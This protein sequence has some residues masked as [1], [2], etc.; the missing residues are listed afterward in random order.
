MHHTQI[1]FGGVDILANKAE[2]IDPITRIAKND[3]EA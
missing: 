2:L 1:T 3:P